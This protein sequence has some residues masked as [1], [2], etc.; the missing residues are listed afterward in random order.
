MGLST[1]PKTVYVAAPSS[2]AKDAAKIIAWVNS[3]GHEI[4]D[5]T[6]DPGLSNPADAQPVM[7]ALKDLGGVNAAQTLGLI[8][9]VAK[10]VSEGASFEAAAAFAQGIPVV[11]LVPHSWTFRGDSEKKIFS[12]LFPM[13]N[14]PFAA[15]QVLRKME[16]LR[17]TLGINTLAAHR[18]VDALKH[19][20]FYS[21]DEMK[22]MGGGVIW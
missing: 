1:K 10:P 3:R 18:L 4:Y 19:T 17:P 22:N 20:K 12:T 9:M 6:R 2:I 13:V 11:C 14:H 16:K 21:T 7:S 5:W 8:W 15:L